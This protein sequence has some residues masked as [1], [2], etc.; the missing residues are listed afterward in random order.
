M[1][2]EYWYLFPISVAIATTAMVFAHSFLSEAFNNLFVGIWEY[3]SMKLIAISVGGP[4][5]VLWKGWNA[6]RQQL[7]GA[8]R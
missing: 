7:S 8:I 2:L 5:Q 6:N 3:G 1:P 4:R